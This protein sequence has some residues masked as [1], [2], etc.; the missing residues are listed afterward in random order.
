MG[1]GSLEFEMGKGSLEFEMGKGSLEFEM[2]KGSLNVILTCRSKRGLR[3]AE[4][5]VR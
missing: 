3:R 5:G 1:K 2:A 4:A